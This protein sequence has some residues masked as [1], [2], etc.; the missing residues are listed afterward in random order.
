MSA[1]LLEIARKTGFSVSTVSRVLH[2]HSNKYKI[3]AATKDLVRKTAEEL[4]YRPNK[5][6]RGL[7]LKQTHEIGVII[8]DISNPFFATLVKSIAGELRK[9]GYSI[10]V[11]DSDEN[12][13][14]EK[15][16]VKILL[17]KKVDGLI[18]APVGQEAAHLK[19]IAAANTAWVMID[20][21][22]EDLEADAVS[23]DNVRGAYLATQYL[24][25]EG[26]RHIAFIQGL[27][28]TYVNEGRLQG[29]KQALQEANLAIDE[30]LIV[31]DDFRN[32]NG[33]LETKLLLKLQEPPSAIFTAGDLIAM[34]ALE[35]LQE[36]HSRVPQ[37]ISLVTFDDPSFATYLSPALTTVA[38][39]VEKMGEM[40]VKLLFRRLRTPKVEWRRILLEPR[41]VVRDSVMRKSALALLRQ[42]S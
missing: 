5:L 1:R 26:H 13:V 25:R 35:A 19:Q 7:R 39:P 33:Y 21:C 37:D 28:G 14:I 12:A 40:A 8:P 34:G 4:D 9:S 18:I 3:S 16:S 31:G 27:L 22:F 10:F 17:E 30:R 41:L 20:R 2:D 38:Q 29:Y 15:E 36:D 24:I 42:V 23:V 6:A 32:Y 11:C